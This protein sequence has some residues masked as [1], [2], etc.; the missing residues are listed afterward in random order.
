M[1][2]DHLKNMWSEEKISETPEINTDKKKEIHLP[3]EKIRAN[4]RMEFWTNILIFTALIAFFFFWD[5]H[6]IRFRTFLIAVIISMMLVTVFY[7]LKFFKLYKDISSVNLNTVESLR[8]LN[9]QFKLNEQYYLSYYVAFAPFI[10]CEM[11][12]IFDY[13]PTLKYI[14][15]VK[16]VLA[17]AASCVGMLLF[18]YFFGK[19]WFQR[20]Y[21]KY[22]EQVRRIYESLN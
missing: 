18:L 17:F 5:V 14:A 3:L 11:F 1:D 8:D 21:G 2:L 16:F 9:F 4:M 7:F 12:L 20:Y 19:F 15:D 6:S 10:I 13:S 22:F